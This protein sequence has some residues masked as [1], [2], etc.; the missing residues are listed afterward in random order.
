MNY[1]VTIW[2][3]GGSVPPELALV[4]KLTER[5][6]RVVVLAGP[7]LQRAVEAAGA[8]FRPWQDVP[9]RRRPEDEDP[10]SDTRLSAPQRIVGMLLDRVIAGPSAAYS[11]EVGAALDEYGSDALVSSMLM[12]GGMVA[13][14]ARGVPVGVMVPNC[15]LMP[16]RGMPPFGTP[17]RP[18]RTPLGRTRDALIHGMTTRM[19][20]RGLARLNTTRADLGL[21]PLTHVFDQHSRAARVLVMTSPAFDFPA[22][23]PDNVRYVGPQ[24]DDPVWVDPVEPPPGDQPLVLV[25]MSS[26]FMDQADLLRRVVAALDALP[27]RGLV[28]TGPEIDPAEVPGSSRVRVVRAAP[29]R[30]ILPSCAAVVSHG[31]H[32]TVIKAA[33]AGV[34]QLVIP[35]GRDQPNN[36]ARI[37]AAG[38]GLRLKP[39]AK[40]AAIAAALHRLLDEP[41]FTQR[42]RHLAGRI[43]ADAHSTTALTELEGL[44]HPAGDHT[45]T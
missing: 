42:A 19:W 28:T 15:Y 17:W 36:A 12:L 24:L 30:E 23:L 7:P 4:R 3:A 11:R 40:P 33:A 32:G 14:E 16:A 31:G 8:T 21:P 25:G 9:H 10:F 37:V 1:L 38:T 35:L 43:T 41:S 18:A 6:H 44:A 27:V 13:A 2:D 29:H 22:E 39:T 45:R 26:T 20:D 5:G 34:P